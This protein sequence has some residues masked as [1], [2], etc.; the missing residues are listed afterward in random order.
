MFVLFCMLI[1]SSGN[2]DTHTHIYIY[3]YLY[4]Y[5]YIHIHTCMHACIPIYM[6][7]SMHAYIH[8]YI[9]TYTDATWQ[10]YAAT[11]V[12]ALISINLN[13][14]G[15]YVSQYIFLSY[16]QLHVTYTL[17]L[18]FAPYKHI[19]TVGLFVHIL[20]HFCSVKWLNHYIRQEKTSMHESYG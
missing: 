13:R 11:R 4:I 5:I 8:T 10:H 16:I 1:P 12:M 14:N 6:H 3:I 7:A 20:F 17:L 19:S 9:H 18:G 15:L 2:K